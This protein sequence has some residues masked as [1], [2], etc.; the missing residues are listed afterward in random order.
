VPNLFV[1]LDEY[2]VCIDGQERAPPPTA[3]TRPSMPLATEGIAMD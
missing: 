3:S 2:E 1:E